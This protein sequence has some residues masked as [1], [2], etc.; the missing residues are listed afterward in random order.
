MITDA[1]GR[2]YVATELGV[3]YFDPTAA[4]VVS[5]PVRMASR[6]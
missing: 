1:Y 4:S 2:Y 5:F 6:G 3:Q